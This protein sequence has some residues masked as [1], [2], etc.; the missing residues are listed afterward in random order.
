VRLI[1]LGR[2]LAVGEVEIVSDGLSDMAAHAT[3]TYALK[4]VAQG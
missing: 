3:A 2:R 4:T 1:R